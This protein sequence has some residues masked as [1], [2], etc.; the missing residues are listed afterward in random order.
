MSTR[1]IRVA[2][3]VAMLLCLFALPPAGRLPRAG[4]QIPAPFPG[5]DDWTDAGTCGGVR[6]FVVRSKDDGRNDFELKIKFENKNKH[7]V[8]LRYDAVI[9]SEGG[10]KK[11]RSGGAGRI[12]VERTAEGCA[13]MPNLCWGK[14]FQAAVYQQKPTGVK[15]VTITK[16]DVANIDAPP[17]NAPP[18]AY[19]DA[20]RDFPLSTCKDLKVGFAGSK[21]PRFVQLT[22]S[23]V[24]GLPRW[25]K[26]DCD[27]AVQELITAY[28][29][30]APEDQSCILEW[31]KYQ[32]CYEIYAFNSSPSP[33]PACSPPT[34][35]LKE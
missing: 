18:S 1:K 11:F 12:N 32:K 14:P 27:D 8:Q 4:A 5:W 28:N 21:G 6:I 23:C 25:T 13:M 24:K 3:L 16:I 33:P 34:C 17:P 35:K 19:L 15:S 9:E 30:A 7:T 26:P 22:Q 10:E 31:R 20:F 2:T 29:G